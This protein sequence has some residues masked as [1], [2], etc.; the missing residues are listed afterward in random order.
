M[1][2]ADADSL[3]AEAQANSAT[4]RRCP[5]G[6]G[7]GPHPVRCLR[8]DQARPPAPDFWRPHPGATQ[9]QASRP[10]ICPLPAST[11]GWRRLTR[12]FWKAANGCRRRSNTTTTACS[13]W[14]S[15]CLFPVN[16]TRWSRL[17]GRWVWDVDF[18]R[19]ATRIAQE[20]LKSAAPALVKPYPEWLSEDYFIFHVREVS[21]TPSAEELCSSHGPQIAQIVRGETA[22]IVGRRTQRNSAV[23]DF[24]LSQRFGGHRLERGFPL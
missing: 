14:S 5:T 9:L 13:A 10:G 12:W 16:G 18:V 4:G 7:I 22:Q 20:R 1:I 24:L 6:L 23:A 3:V 11:G 21:G 2:R 17:G 19:H 15:S 8:G